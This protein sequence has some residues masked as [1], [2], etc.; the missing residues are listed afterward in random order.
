M[1]LHFC[2]YDL[3]GA[4]FGDIK[5]KEPEDTQDIVPMAAAKI[6]FEKGRGKCTT[7]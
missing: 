3:R 7:K 6:A 2:S 5:C 1:E 4:E